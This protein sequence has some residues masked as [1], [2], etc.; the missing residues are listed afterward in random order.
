M[1]QWNN[2][3]RVHGDILVKEILGDARKDLRWQPVDRLQHV[4]QRRDGSQNIICSSFETFDLKG[5]GQNFP[6]G[7]QV[8]VHSL[9]SLERL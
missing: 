7:E 2:Q 3:P 9:Q 1:G 8:N 6:S 4:P 5:S